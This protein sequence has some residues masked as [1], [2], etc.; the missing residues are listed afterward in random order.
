MFKLKNINK[1]YIYSSL[2]TTALVFSLALTIVLTQAFN[3]E[4]DESGSILVSG[5][6]ALDLKDYPLAEKYFSQAVKLNPNDYK[7]LRSLAEVKV[8][9]GKFKES[10]ALL[11]RILALPATTGRDIIIYL[12]G[13]AKPHDAEIVD[14]TVMVI[15]ESP[16]SE[17]LDE[18][19]SKFIKKA[20]REPVPHYRV[21]L[22]DTGKMKLTPKSKA[23]V[24]Y[25]GIPT[26]TREE[27]QFYKSEV[28]KMIID[29]DGG[30]VDDAMISIPSGCFKMGSEKG[31]PNELPVHDVC[32]SAF[33]IGKYE[34]SQKNFQS[35]MGFNPS[36]NIVSNHPVDSVSW[37]DARNYCRKRGL[38]LP[39][40]AEWEYAARGGT[41]TEYYWGEELQ[42]KMENF[43]DSMCKYNNRNPDYTDGFKNTAPIGSFDPNPFGLHDMVG[44][45]SEWV[46]DWMDIDT[47]YYMM[48]QKQDPPGP[49]PDLD[50]CMG[51]SCAGSF[52]ITQK[53]FRAGSW[54]K[55]ARTMRSAHRGDAHFQL[56]PDG[57]GFRCAASSDAT[58][59]TN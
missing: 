19:A 29:A 4:A 58:E 39:T 5:E 3:L 48:G 16:D 21:Y 46:Q 38:R 28:Q 49:R 52:S 47:N 37:L 27:T 23:R 40:E 55:Q 9:L 56:R 59:K 25:K 34:V 41:Q 20:P 14:E 26:S 53:V 8:K 44:N 50:A 6:K 32:I 1:I 31:N 51:V 10:N 30:E 43:C 13:D 54:N 17:E 33:K 22:K 11:D 35:V 57:V 2:S 18:P 12:P 42:D 36:Q 24:A 15:D 45:L 7:A